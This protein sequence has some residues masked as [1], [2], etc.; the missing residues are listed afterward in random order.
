VAFVYD[1]DSDRMQIYFDGTLDET[2][3][4]VSLP[5]VTGVDLTIGA[6]FEG[7]QHFF[8]G[9]IDGVALYDQALKADQIRESY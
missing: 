3:V 8:T 1:D 2:A 9:F 7:T 6:D 4:T 5:V